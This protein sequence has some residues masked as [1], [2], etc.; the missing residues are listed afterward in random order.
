MN[1]T[2]NVKQNDNDIQVQIAGE[3]DVYSAPSLRE[4]LVPLAEQGADIHICL[5]D[6]S[7]MDSTGLGVF[8]GV[9]KTVKKEGGS[10]KLENLSERLIRLF[11]ITGLKD[12]IDISAKSEG[13]VQ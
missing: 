6:V 8:V 1:L 12:I 7:Y 2:V 4:K 11:E 10:L 9:F 13:G 5:K 3:I